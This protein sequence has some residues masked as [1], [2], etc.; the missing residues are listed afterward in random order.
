MILAVAGL[1]LA[2][3]L[4]GVGEWSGA[5]LGLGT[6]GVVFASRELCRA[7]LEGSRGRRHP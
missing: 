4:A 6:L 7:L 1:P 3:E 5:S 2:S